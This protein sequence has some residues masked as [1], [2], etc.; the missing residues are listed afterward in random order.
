MSVP[1]V[2]TPKPRSASALPSARAFLDDLPCVG[3]KLRSCGF[4]RGDGDA[5]RHVIVR[6]SLQPGE[7]GLVDRGGVLLL[8]QDH[9]PARPPEGLVRRG[10]HD[11]RDA[12]RGRVLPPAHQPGD[13]RHVH[14]QKRVHL[15]RD[16]AECRE[17]EQ[18]R[19]GRR[20]APDEFRTVFARQRAHL[21]DVDAVVVF[22][23]AVLDAFEVLARDRDRVSVGQ[24][25]AGRERKAHDGVARGAERE[26]DGEIGR[27]SGVG[28]HVD[29]LGPEVRAP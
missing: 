17:V 13:V 25:A 16:G 19:V 8:A 10:G 23:D 12:D 24:V 7:H 11:V 3:L 26:V 27:A 4:A 9:A 2:M 28:L 5:R 20:P 6:A 21:V 22:S 14:H 29:V 18:A 1:P 15:V